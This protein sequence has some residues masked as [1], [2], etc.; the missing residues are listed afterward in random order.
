MNSSRAVWPIR[1]LSATGS[2]TP[3]TW[4]RSRSSPW[5]MT[6]ISLVPPGSMRRRTTSRATDIAFL[7]AWVEPLRSG[8]SRPGSNRP[9]GRPSRGCRS[10]FRPAGSGCAAARPRHRPGPG[11]GPG[12][13]AARRCSKCRRYRSAGRGEARSRPNRPSPGAAASWRRPDPPRAA[14]CE[15]PARSRPRLIF[16]FGSHDGQRASSG[17][18]AIRLGM[19]RRMPTATASDTIQTFQRGKSSTGAKT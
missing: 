1:R 14:R 9:P 5:V 12:T 8:S 18:P 17:L 3:G 6:V 2:S 19:E 10:A 11:C 16:W 15:P 4:T 13:T 7:S